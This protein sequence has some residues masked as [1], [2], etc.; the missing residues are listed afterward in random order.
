M[1]V[2]QCHFMYFGKGHSNSSVRA[3]IDWRS[4]AK[5]LMQQIVNY[6]QKKTKKT[7]PTQKKF[8]KKK[9][10]LISKYCI[11]AKVSR[12][13]VLLLMRC[14]FLTMFEKMQTLQNPGKVIV[15]C[16]TLFQSGEKNARV[17][18]LYDSSQRHDS[19]CCKIAKYPSSCTVC[20]L[21]S[22]SI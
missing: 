16:T 15:S 6:F 9:N 5:M 22:D 8:L 12:G 3:Q 13:F 7:H 19:K 2:R 20:I 4:L 21:P 11:K 1:L 14:K 10:S 18:K 17:I